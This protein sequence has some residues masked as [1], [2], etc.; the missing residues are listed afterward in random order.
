M[1][2]TKTSF[3]HSIAVRSV[4]EVSQIEWYQ[5]LTRHDMMNWKVLEVSQIEWYQNSFIVRRFFI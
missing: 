5:N 1:S 4:L 2:G 3:C